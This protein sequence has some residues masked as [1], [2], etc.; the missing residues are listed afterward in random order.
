MWNS[1]Y[2]VMPDR[3]SAMYNGRG[4]NHSSRAGTVLKLSSDVWLDDALSLGMEL[5]GLASPVADCEE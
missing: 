1:G 5:L 4:R 3:T 2:L